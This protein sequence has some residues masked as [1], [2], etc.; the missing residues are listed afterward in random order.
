M[1]GRRRVLFYRVEWL[2]LFDKVMFE[3][4]LKERG[5]GIYEDI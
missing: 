2:S 5:T 3:H 1:L 4:M